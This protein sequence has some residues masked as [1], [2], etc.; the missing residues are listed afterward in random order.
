MNRTALATWSGM[1]YDK[2]SR[3]LEWMTSRKLV[4]MDEDSMVEITS[5]GVRTKEQMVQ[6]II[7]FVG[8][9]KFT[10]RKF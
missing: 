2:F 10:R 9:M 6:W 3:Y 8:R 4:R 1:S 5:D 7:D